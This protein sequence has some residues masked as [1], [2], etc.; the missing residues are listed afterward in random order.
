[1]YNEDIKRR[2][3]AEKEIMA[4]VPEN[5]LKNCFNSVEETEKEYGKDI[6][7]FTV[8]E[9]ISYYKIL[10]RTSLE[11]LQV[12]NST[13]S[14]YTQFC[15]Q[16]NL[17]TDNQNHFLEID[18]DLLSSC[19]NKAILDMKIIDRKTVLSW[20]E[21]LQN[22]RDQ[23]ILLF[24]FECGKSNNYET[25]VKAE[26]DDI[27][28]NILNT[29]D[30]RKVKISNKLKEI[31]QESYEEKKYYGTTG[32]CCKKMDLVSNGKRIV[33]NYPNVNTDD[34]LQVG[35]RIYNTISRIFDYIGIMNVHSS[36]SISESGKIE[37]IKRRAEELE[38]TPLEYIYSSHIDE[39]ENQYGCKIVRS[40]FCKKYKEYL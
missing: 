17:V 25:I 28:G 34:P 2:Y 38:M 14:T 6:S 30:G 8:Y 40:V 19:V 12:L 10:N 3:I 24:L 7:N 26:I 36:N 29:C 11:S 22:P 16:E 4:V 33:K 21:V 18:I 23:F 20:V 13:F 15:L 37:M 5:Y 31:A 35:R 39:V 32:K 27:D 1:M 9:I